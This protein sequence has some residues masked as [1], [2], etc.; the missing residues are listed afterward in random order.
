[1]S[2]EKKRQQAGW[3]VPAF[4]AFILALIGIRYASSQGW[5]DKMWGNT[6]DPSRRDYTMINTGLS[7]QASNQSEVPVGVQPLNPDRPPQPPTSIDSGQTGKD[8][9]RGQRGLW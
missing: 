6:F 4:I 1:M 2:A 8:S 3:W 7:V 9:E 5:W